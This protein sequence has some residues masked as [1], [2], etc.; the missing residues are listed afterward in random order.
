MLSMTDWKT[1]G[2]PA[3]VVLHMQKDMMREGN[4][5]PTPDLAKSAVAAIINS[6][7]INRIQALL[8]AFRNKNLPVIFVNVF[9]NPLDTKAVYGRYFKSVNEPE[10]V[11]GVSA[12]LKSQYVREGLEVI[13]E[14]NRKPEE[15]IL[16]NWFL[17][18]FNNSGLDLALKTKG[19][20]TVILVGFAAHSAVYHTAVQAVDLHYSVI[21]PRDATASPLQDQKAFEAV[22]EIMAPSIGLVTTTDDVI[23]HL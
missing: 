3:L 12:I 20:K 7:M 11:G 21:M 8:E 14:L 1:D 13:P 16:F 22:M 18:A 23:A 10:R 6:G 17:N 15:P 4:K 19:V 5:R 9:L 2:N